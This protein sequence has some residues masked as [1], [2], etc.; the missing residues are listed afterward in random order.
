MARMVAMEAR[1]RLGA[2]QEI[3]SLIEDLKD[4]NAAIRGQAA[5]ALA[6]LAHS[7]GRNSSAHSTITGTRLRR[8]A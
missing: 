1:H 8:R 4:R 6:G 2:E 7:Q 5:L 3:T